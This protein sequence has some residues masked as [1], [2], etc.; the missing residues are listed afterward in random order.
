MNMT[1]RD[2]QFLE[3]Q[4]WLLTKIMTVYGMQPIVLGVIDPTTG[5]LNSAEQMEAYRNET[6]KPLLELECYQLTKVL[7]QQGFGYD[8]VMITYDSLD[9]RDEI[10]DAGIATS[11]VQGGILTPNEARK[12]YFQLPPIEGADSLVQGGM[13]MGVEGVPGINPFNAQE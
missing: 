5:K 11:L 9:S 4:K 3:Y 6:V 1:N 8:D 12:M 7:V 13:G 2:M 10:S